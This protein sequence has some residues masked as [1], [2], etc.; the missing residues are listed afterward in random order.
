MGSFVELAMFVIIVLFILRAVFKSKPGSPKVIQESS[1]HGHRCYVDNELTP[2]EL[3]IV[4]ILAANLSH[5]EYFIFNNLML[6]S[7]VLGTTQIDHV[8]VSRY[9]IFVIESKDYKGW[10]FANKN[11][12][13]WTQSMPR[14]YKYKF[15]NPILQNFAHI[16]ALREQL[17]FIKNR[18]FSA[19]VFSK[20]AEFKTAMPDGVMYTSELVDFIRTRKEPIF[21]EVELLVVIGKLSMLCQTIEVTPEEHVENVQQRIA[22]AQAVPATH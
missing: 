13:E 21:K 22:L 3:D 6:P 10:I 12:K 4:H 15:Y 2:A 14:G 1:R 18:F 9:G 17:P 19:V 11:Q 5:R 7:T 20:S 16:S 8:V